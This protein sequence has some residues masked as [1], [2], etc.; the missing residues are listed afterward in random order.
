MTAPR[1]AVTASFAHGIPHFQTKLPRAS[2]PEDVTFYHAMPYGLSDPLRQKML[3]GF[4]V[5]TRAVHE[6]KRAGFGAHHSQGHWLDV[7]QGMDFRPASMDEMSR[8]VERLSER[9]EHAEGWRRQLHLGMSFMD[10]DPLSAALEG[11]CSRDALY[12]EAPLVPR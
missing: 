8:L 9:F 5:N 11:D 1:L 4:P 6:R 10:L 12:E 7:S 3:A 2:F